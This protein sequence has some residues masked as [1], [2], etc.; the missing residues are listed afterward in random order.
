MRRELGRLVVVMGLVLSGWGVASRCLVV[1]VE[2]VGPVLGVSYT[3][4][5]AGDQVCTPEEMGSILAID[6]EIAAW[7]W[8]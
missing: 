6:E 3:R 5:R 8:S 7:H 1:V 2:A 4:P